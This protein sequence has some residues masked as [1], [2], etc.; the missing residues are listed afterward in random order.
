M[1]FLQEFMSAKGTF[2]MWSITK[3][4]QKIREAIANGKLVRFAAPKHN[5]NKIKDPFLTV[6]KKPI[7]NASSISPA[8][9][10]Y[11]RASEK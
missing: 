8:A 11:P 3:I 2:F 10:P 1:K 5:P 7:T 6:L 4:A 9:R